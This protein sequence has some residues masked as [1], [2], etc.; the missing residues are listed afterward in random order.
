MASRND[1]IHL[2]LVLH[3]NDVAVCSATPQAVEQ[4]AGRLVEEF[5]AASGA[6]G[7]TM[8]PAEIRAAC[9]PPLAARLCAML[10][11]KAARDESRGGFI[12]SALSFLVTLAFRH[13]RGGERY[14]V[15]I[16]A[17]GKVRVARRPH[18]LLARNS[19][20]LGNHRNAVAALLLALALAASGLSWQPALA[21]SDG[22][23]VHGE[24][25]TAD[26]KLIVCLDKETA[27]GVARAVNGALMG[28]REEIL[29][30]PD[31]AA[32]QAIYENKLYPS[33]G[34][35]HLMGMIYEQR[36][37]L[38]DEA[39]HVSQR[40]VAVGPPELVAIAASHSVVESEMLYGEAQAPL[41]VWV[42]TT[43][44]V[45]PVGP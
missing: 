28:L 39:D 38:V 41:T 6:R 18:R 17:D 33:V 42:V 14:T 25:R 13:P 34:W 31:D 2:F 20:V 12:E 16:A 5:R 4:A 21:E 8:A 23:Y 1:P 44:P 10:S 30:A 3:G 37:S 43:E 22:P 9:W 24:T 35:Q 15:H 19:V 36:C 45:P 11:D 29:A 27:L 26:Q 40:T 32:R 7:M